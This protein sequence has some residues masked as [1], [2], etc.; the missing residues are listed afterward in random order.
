MKRMSILLVLLAALGLVFG[1]CS[2]TTDP[3]TPTSNLEDFGDYTAENEAPNFGNPD[4]AELTAD[5]SE[6]PIDDPVALSP[7]VDSVENLEHPDIFCLR[8]VWG[9]LQGDTGVTDLTDWSGSLTLSRGAVVV[10][11][12]IRFEPGQDYLLPRYNDSGFY[13]PEE[14]HWVSQTS[15]HFDGLATRLFFPPVVVDT[16]DTNAV[17]PE[18][19]TVT[20]ESPQLTITFTMDE[21]EDLDTLVSIGFGNAVSFQAQRCDRMPHLKGHLI[22]RWGRDDEGNGIFYGRWLSNRGRLMGTLEGEWGIDTTGARVFVGKYI[23]TEGNFTGFIKGLWRDRGRGRNASGQFRGRIYDADREPIGVLK[24]HFKKG[25]TRKGG[26]F[27]GRW[28]VG[29]NNIGL[30]SGF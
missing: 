12:T 10:T 30:F 5:D 29:C 6:K 9:N 24:G 17:E 14:L 15:W 23:D 22:G 28:C 18:P 4:I 3:T 20:Y 27:A 16:S 25:E 7:V 26:Y 21:L 19:V 13:V 8:V 11:H 1:G 2:S